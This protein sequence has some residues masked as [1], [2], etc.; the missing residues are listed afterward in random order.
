MGVCHIR[1]RWKYLVIIV[2]LMIFSLSVSIFMSQNVLS[3]ERYEYDNEKIETS[4][5]IVQISDLHNHEFGKSN[6]RL[7][8]KI[9]REQPDVIFMTGDMLNDDEERTDIVENLIR[10]LKKVADV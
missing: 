3:I 7:V 4:F 10:E 8:K 6:D 5:K 2:G 1:F 9:K